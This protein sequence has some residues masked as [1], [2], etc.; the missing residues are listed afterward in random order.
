MANQLTFSKHG[1]AREILSSLDK[2]DRESLFDALAYIKDAPFEHG[3]LITR[4]LRPPVM[5]YTYNDGDWRI[6]YTLHT[7]P[8]QIGFHI[9][10]SHITLL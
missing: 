1:N 9:G 5:V 6:L 2:S 7:I 3:G 10:I 4:Q 8:G